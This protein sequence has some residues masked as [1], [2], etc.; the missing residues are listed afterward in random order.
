MNKYSI[1]VGLCKNFW[2]FGGVA[3]RIFTVSSPDFACFFTLQRYHR[4]KR[5]PA[6]F[7]T[8]HDTEKGETR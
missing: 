7:R 4:R 8:K 2:I 5:K 3:V 1:R 6:Y